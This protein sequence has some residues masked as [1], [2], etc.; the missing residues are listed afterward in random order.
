MTI[1]HLSTS[2]ENLL[3]QLAE[4]STKLAR[5]ENITAL[6]QKDLAHQR[7]E[8]D[9]TRHKAEILDSAA[10]TMGATIENINRIIANCKHNFQD[11]IKQVNAEGNTDADSLKLPPY[12]DTSSNDR[13]TVKDEQLPPSATADMFE[14]NGFN[15]TPLDPVKR[16]DGGN[17]QSH[18]QQE[19]HDGPESLTSSHMTQF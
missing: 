3:K 5:Q 4:T 14:T 11:T 19:D 2:N 18:G 10:Q 15:G 17:V 9:N 8:A 16:A 6:L 13:E 12:V 1:W 7:L